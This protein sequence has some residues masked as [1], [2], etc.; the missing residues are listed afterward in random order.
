MSLISIIEKAA[1]P[2]LIKA[3]NSK[4]GFVLFEISRSNI[5]DRVILKCTDTYKELK[6]SKDRFMFENCNITKHYIHSVLKERI[7]AGGY[8]FTDRQKKIIENFKN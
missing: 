8:V 2:N 7:E 6:P 4:K 1:T 5:A 3:L